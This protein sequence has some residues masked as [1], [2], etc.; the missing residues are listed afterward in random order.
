MATP[1]RRAR[2][3]RGSLG[4][5]FVDRRHRLGLTQSELA[6]LAGVSRSSVQS[7]ESGRATVQLDLVV[8]I[9]DALGCDLT[10]TT[11]GDRAG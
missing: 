8:A 2:T 1:R 3:G 6:D 5:H 10:L 7:L 9:A 11:R 4:D